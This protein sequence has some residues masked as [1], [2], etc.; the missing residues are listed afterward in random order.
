MKTTFLSQLTLFFLILFY[1]TALSGARAGMDFE[2]FGPFSDEEK[3]P[4]ISLNPVTPLSVSS[5]DNQ[6]LQILGQT[7]DHPVTLFKIETTRNAQGAAER[8]VIQ[9]VRKGKK[10]K[11]MSLIL[12]KIS[13][14]AAVSADLNG[15]GIP[16][17]V[18]PTFQSTQIDNHSEDQDYSAGA[19]LLV[20]LSS[21]PKVWKAYF[22]PHT[23]LDPQA[24]L[25]LKNDG[26]SWILQTAFL[27]DTGAVPKVKGD[28]LS[29][30]LYQ[31]L[32][33]DKEGLRLDTVTDPRF[34]KFVCQASESLR[35]NHKETKLLTDEQKKKLLADHPVM[36][37]PM[38]FQKNAPK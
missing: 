37:T 26:R 33:V 11:P 34:P 15:D 20:L 2:N 16:D 28:D 18:F 36:I 4:L 17:Y 5:V 25:N 35:K 6:D 23:P 14:G 13:L 22:I 12:D 10:L 29:F 38:A 32:V 30:Y 7:G 8:T 31:L 9:W 1:G 27:R 24:F 3:V 21:G 19:G